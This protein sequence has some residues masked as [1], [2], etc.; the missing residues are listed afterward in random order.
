MNRNLE[1]RFAQLPHIDIERSKF[2]RSSGHTTSFNVGDLIP[3]FWDEVLPGDTFNTT[4]SV[5]ARLQT[6]L[7][8]VMGNVYL[9]TYY[10]FV[11]LRIVWNHAKEFFGENTDSAWAPQVE[12]PKPQISSP[13]GGWNVGTIADYMGIPVGVD[14]NADNG[15]TVDSLPFRAYAMICDQWFRDQ[16]LTDPL[17]INLGDSNDEGSN[18]DNYI[19]DIALGGKPFKAAKF[20][21]YFTS[22]LPSPQKGPAVNFTFDGSVGFDVLNPAYY[23]SSGNVV[24]DNA[25]RVRT[26]PKYLYEVKSSDPDNTYGNYSPILYRAG[27]S[28]GAADWTNYYEKKNGSNLTVALVAGDPSTSTPGDQK[29]NPNNLYVD[30]GDLSAD[31]S[32]FGFTINQLRLAFQL[33]K[34]YEK[35][36]RAGSRYRETILEMFGVSSPDARMMIPEYLGGHRFPLQIHQVTNSAQ[37]SG[38]DLGEVGAMS[39]TSDIHS[40][41]IKSFTEHGFVI[42][43]CVARYDHSYPQGLARE[44]TRKDKFDYYWPVFANIGEQPVYKYEIN[45]SAYTAEGEETPDYEERLKV[46]GYQEAYASYRYK[47]NRVSSLMRPG[48]A[49]TLAHWNLADHYDS[50]VSLSDEWIREEKA[51]VDRALAVSSALS[52][53]IFADFWIQNEVVRAMPMFSIPGLIDH[54]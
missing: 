1:S 34:F 18:G 24:L 41:F 42:G 15:L 53:Q 12:Y 13:V 33:Q 19:T 46:F 36:A 44:W 29:M 8:P 47:Q 22:A 17:S 28:S 25:L 39:N 3:F 31:L 6:L 51:N 32:E 16:N 54:H 43:L 52:D 23:Y 27:A 11:P 2:D 38:N 30:I 20:H 21:D 35:Q 50:A 49:N 26:Y 10:F 5:V 45:A 9:D 14:F 37:S 7:T 48:V 4:T 40:D